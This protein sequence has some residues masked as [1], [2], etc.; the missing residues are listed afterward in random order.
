[1]RC[2]QQKRVVAAQCSAIV[3]PPPVVLGGEGVHSAPPD[4]QVGGIV[5]QA[6]AEGVAKLVDGFSAPDC[7]SKGAINPSWLPPMLCCGWKGA[8]QASDR[9]LSELKDG[10]SAP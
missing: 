6:S 3:A 2:T 1:M 9:G 7:V 4:G 5:K 8:G 10:V